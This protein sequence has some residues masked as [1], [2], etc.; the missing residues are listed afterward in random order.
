MCYYQ[1]SLLRMFNLVMRFLHDFKYFRA[2]DRPN[3]RDIS[4]Y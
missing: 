2:K 1:C 3:L 4:D